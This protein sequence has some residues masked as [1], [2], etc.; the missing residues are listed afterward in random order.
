MCPAR[1]YSR[2]KAQEA[3]ERSLKVGISSVDVQSQQQQARLYD[4]A[5]PEA[6]EETCRKGVTTNKPDRNLWPSVQSDEI[7]SKEVEGIDCWIPFPLN[8]M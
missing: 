2:K 6:F 4:S 5:L 7:N 8:R 1:L 3:V